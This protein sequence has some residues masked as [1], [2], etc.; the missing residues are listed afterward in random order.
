VKEG[1]FPNILNLGFTWSII[2]TFWH[3]SSYH[4][5]RL[6]LCPFDCAQGAVSKRRI[7]GVAGN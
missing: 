2:F 7:P 6:F 3:Q 5:G 1:K 4:W